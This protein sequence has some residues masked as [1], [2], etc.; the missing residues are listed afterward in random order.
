MGRNKS[1]G[2]NIGRNIRETDNLLLLI[3]L[4]ASAFGML[5]VYSATYATLSDGEILSGDFR[6]MF[7]AVPLGIFTAL[8]I[9]MINY[10]YFVKFFWLV[11]VAGLLLMAA[12]IVF[13]VAPDERQ[14]S[15]CWLK[16]GSFYFQASEVV[17]IAF[18][19]TFAVHLNKVKDNIN[20]IKNVI[21]LV[22]HAL[23]PIGLVIITGDDG[24]A[25]VFAL[26][27]IGMLISAGLH[28]I[29][30]L[31]GGLAVT[32]AVPLVWSTGILKDFQKERFLALIYFDDEK[33]AQSVAYQQ[34]QA[35]NAIGSGQFNGKGLFKGD[36]IQTGA[37]P[38]AKNDMVLAV[39]GEE[40]G[41]LGSA[42]VV[43]I[44][45][46]IVI[47]IIFDAKNAKDNHGYLI[48]MGIASMLL[49]QV[50]INMGMCL[51]LL[52]V[53]GITLPFF[54]AGGSSNL[55]VYLAIGVV[56]SVYRQSKKQQQYNMFYDAAPT[57]K[58]N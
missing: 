45:T 10:E 21:L 49:G 31:A 14:D 58:F 25:L 43:I 4:I 9:S 20:S 42:A 8:V 34:N 54:S 11:A 50:L 18:V 53:I 13:G 2:K 16:F 51:R 12:T 35:I 29:Y 44:L 23:I 57:L 17:K 5:L 22:L 48:C 7:I 3:C 33:Y 24:S 15:R 30:F 26:I 52:P 36:Y 40:L 46:L 37:V 6:T 55:A 39:A 56:L 32:A 28:W 41:F 19:I 27:F 47:K 1:L 38:E